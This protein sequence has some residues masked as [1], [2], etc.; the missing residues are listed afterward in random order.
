MIDLQTLI[1]ER[2]TAYNLA[3]NGNKILLDG[4]LNTAGNL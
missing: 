1:T 3:T 2:N 4:K